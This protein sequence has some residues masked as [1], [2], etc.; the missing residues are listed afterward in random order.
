MSIRN[1]KNHLAKIL[2]ILLAHFLL[3]CQNTMTMSTH[4]GKS[5]WGFMVPEG[6]YKMGGKT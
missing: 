3:L 5:L 4:R 1:Y 6:E 2:S